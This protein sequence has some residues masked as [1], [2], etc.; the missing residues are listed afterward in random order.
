M[1]STGKDHA[2][3]NLAIWGDD[4]FRDLTPPEQHLYF[5]LWTS[6]GLSYC[7]AGDWHP[8]RLASVAAGWTKRGVMTAAAGLSEKQF[9][10][11]DADTDE[12]LLRSWIKHDGLWRTPNMAVSI[13]NARA[14]LSSRTLRGVIVHEVLKVQAAHADSNSWKRAPVVSMLEQTPIDPADV[15]PYNPDPNPGPK[16]GSNPAANPGSN[17][18]SNPWLENRPNPGPT[19]A[20]APTPTSNSFSLSHESET[21]SEQ[22]CVV[23]TV[24]IPI[25]DDWAPNDLHRAKYPRP[26]LD[27]LAASFR[28]HAISVGRT[29]NGHAG[30]DAA[31]GNWVRKSPAPAIPGMGAG[32]TKAQGWLDLVN[33]LP[34]E[35]DNPEQRA[36]GQ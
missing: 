26:D 10:I 34:P 13:A 33:N 27:E 7:G 36:I 23:E 31:F 19:P 24:L 29:C 4:D 12:F 1:A 21:T 28:D 25:P 22:G 15:D 9:V 32:S 6:P 18:G 30:W 17:P 20:P 3:I 5:V 11:I 35:P 16:G 14:E 8:G 2:R